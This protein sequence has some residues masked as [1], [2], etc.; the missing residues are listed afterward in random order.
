M[1]PSWR[2]RAIEHTP[3]N[4]H[5][6]S[7]TV[8]ENVRR[9]SS[10]SQIVAM[11]QAAEPWHRYNPGTRTGLARCLTTYRFPLRQCKMS[12]VLVVI[13][14]VLIHEPFQMPFID[15]DHMVEQITTAVS[16]PALRNTVL[17]GTSVAGSLRLD[18]EVLHCI[19]HVFNVI[20]L[21]IPKSLPGSITALVNILGINT[22]GYPLQY[23]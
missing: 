6:P 17:P 3:P 4:V 20:C 15:D 2:R 5:L 7:S 10:G 19:D 11:M 13:T 16:G 14:D 18:A 1:R 22:V 8:K 23:T 12:S 9:S 21:R